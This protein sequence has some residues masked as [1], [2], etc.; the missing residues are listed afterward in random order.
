MFSF[1]E[2]D[3]GFVTDEV[4][5]PPYVRYR[6]GSRFVVVSHGRSDF[7]VDVEVGERVGMA[8]KREMTCTRWYIL[9]L[10]HEGVDG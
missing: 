9:V 1:P 3:H 8:P 4:R 5:E 7:M 10:S 2:R 6:N